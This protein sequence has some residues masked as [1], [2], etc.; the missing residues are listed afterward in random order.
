[1][2]DFLHG[3]ETT[4]GGKEIDLKEWDEEF[5][6]LPLPAPTFKSSLL[7]LRNSVSEKLFS[8]EL[9]KISF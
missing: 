8:I 5:T 1:M 4:I 7:K 9:G 6:E 3:K 2:S